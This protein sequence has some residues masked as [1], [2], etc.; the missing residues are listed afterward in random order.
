MDEVVIGIKELLN[1]P[2]AFQEFSKERF[3]HTDKDNSGLID[4]VELEKALKEI[5][6]EMKAP[7]HTKEFVEK[8]LAKFDTDKSGK[9]DQKEFDGFARYVLEN[10]LAQY[11]K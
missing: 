8:T 10:F 3:D 5:A 2:E 9:L 7:K 11:E 1:N 6:E 4:K